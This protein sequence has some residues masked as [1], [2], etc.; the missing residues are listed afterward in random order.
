MQSKSARV[1]LSQ[2]LE[3]RRVLP[4]EQVTEITNL[5]R[6]TLRRNFQDKIIRL[7]PRRLGMRLSDALAIGKPAA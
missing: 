6:D 3:L 4:L 7:S 2:E 5:S 1:Q